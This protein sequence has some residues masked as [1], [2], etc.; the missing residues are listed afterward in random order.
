M[1]SINR[2]TGWF[3]LIT[4][5]K[6]DDS[7]PNHECVCVCVCVSIDCTRIC[8]RATSETCAPYGIHIGYVWQVAENRFLL[9][10]VGDLFAHWMC[11]KIVSRNEDLFWWCL[12]RW[13]YQGLF[14]FRADDPKTLKTTINTHTHTNQKINTIDGQ[15]HCKKRKKKCTHSTDA[16]NWTKRKKNHVVQFHTSVRTQ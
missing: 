3:D 13:F 2:L 1:W 12:P 10:S 6:A 5:G 8:E 9:V 7:I 4:A 15:V 14:V 16:I 11:I